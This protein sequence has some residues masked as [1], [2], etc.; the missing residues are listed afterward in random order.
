MRARQVARV[1]LLGALV[2][3][4]RAL[5][6]AP[7]IC[8][9]RRLTGRPCPA[10]GLTRSWQAAAH[11]RVIDSVRLHP[12]GL[13][14]MAAAAWWA[15]DEGAEDRLERLDRR[16]LAGLTAAWIGVWLSRIS[17]PAR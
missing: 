4:D 15:I 1:L 6:D 5:R 2:L 11:R 12:F 10:C 7:T 8:V 16:W 3:P 17:R 9:F 13:P 14:T